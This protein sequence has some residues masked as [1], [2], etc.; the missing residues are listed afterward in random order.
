[1]LFHGLQ[2]Y[3]FLCAVHFLILSS[4]GQCRATGLNDRLLYWLC[5][6]H[7]LPGHRHCVLPHSGVNTILLSCKHNNLLSDSCNDIISAVIR[8]TTFL[9]LSKKL[10]L[11]V[12]YFIHLNL[13][14]SLFVGYL[15]FVIGIQTARHSMVCTY[16]LCVFLCLSIDYVCVHI[17]L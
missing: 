12:H 15:V 2:C 4:L 17:L 3:N 6:F 1:M 16:M 11:M 14:I 9:F 5:Y 8:D 10:L 13:A 7:G